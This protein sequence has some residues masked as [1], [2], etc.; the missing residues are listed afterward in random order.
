MNEYS[1]K[2]FLSSPNHIRR[3]R[4]EEVGGNKF[5]KIFQF[6]GHQLQPVQSL[7]LLLTQ[8]SGVE[9][10]P[11][12][13]D[14]TEENDGHEV[15]TA[16]QADGYFALKLKYSFGLLIRLYVFQ[17]IDRT[18]ARNFSSLPA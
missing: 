17:D 13:D 16:V 1:N 12:D 14:L 15:A 4:K 10:H 18:S 11:E 2:I 5:W 9:E 3:G 7:S 6:P 8:G